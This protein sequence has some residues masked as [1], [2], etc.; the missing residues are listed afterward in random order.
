MSF[1]RRNYV[2]TS[3]TVL[4]PVHVGDS[5]TSALLQARDALWM[6][7]AKLCDLCATVGD[8]ALLWMRL[9]C[10]ADSENKLPTGYPQGCGVIGEAVVPKVFL[11]AGLGLSGSS[12]GATG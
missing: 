12:R 10:A 6:T 5:V 7:K 3:I 8:H 11:G 1:R 9:W 4:R 2:E